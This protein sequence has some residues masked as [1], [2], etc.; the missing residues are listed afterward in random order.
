VAQP[1]I[2]HAGYNALFVMTVAT[3]AQF[4]K[5]CR[6]VIHRPE[7][8]EQERF[9]GNRSRLANVA[10]LTRLLNG[11][12][13]TGPREEWVARLREAGVPAGVVASVAEALATGLVRTRET[14]REVRHSE[15][16]AYRVL[17]TSAWMQGSEPLPPA[18][19]PALGEHTREVLSGLAGMSEA[20]IDAVLNGCAVA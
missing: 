15:V 2:V 16:G 8:L 18:G 11:V 1:S 7:W 20:E 10:E 5:L 3:K 13:A 12:F 14:M 19:A 4:V 17:R 6:D 9:A